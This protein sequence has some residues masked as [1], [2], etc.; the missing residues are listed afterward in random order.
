MKTIWN[1][2]SILAVANLIAIIGLVGWL[3]KSDRLTMERIRGL[4]EAL[5]ETTADQKAR[6]DA[7][8]AAKAEEAKVLEVKAKESRPPMTAQEKLAVRLEAT[9]LDMQRYKK[10]QSDIEA[11]Q[12]NLRAQAERVAA[13]RGALEKERLAFEA[14]RKEVEN[15]SDDAQFKKA[16]V[17]LE[18]LDAKN[19]V[20]VV[21]Q[22]ISG[23]APAAALGIP[24]ATPNPDAPPAPK[25][26][27]EDMAMRYF[28]AMSPSKRVEILNILA[29]GEPDLAAKLLERLRTYGVMP[30]TSGNSAP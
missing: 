26:T 24:E 13:D 19:A 10:L 18:G 20:A 17:A 2:L 21:K 9:E 29:K 28:N 11:M 30:K 27:G 15:K 25:V 3:A 5:V 23:V 8:T 7:A 16:L 1:I 6:E 4:K 12:T 14:I 22:I